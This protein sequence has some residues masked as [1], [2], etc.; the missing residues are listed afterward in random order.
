MLRLILVASD[1]SAPSRRAFAM[2]LG[3]AEPAG[4]AL[5]L[6][7]VTPSAARGEGLLGGLQEEAQGRGVA[8]RIEEVAGD[9]VETILA[10]AEELDAD[11]LVLGSRGRGAVAEEVLGSVSSGVLRHTQRP[12]LIV[13]AAPA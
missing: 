7:H 6:L 1:G 3:L 8:C 12:L 10:R 9:P 13:R 5:V 4:S 2:A 11:L